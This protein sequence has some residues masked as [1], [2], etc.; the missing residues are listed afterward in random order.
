MAAKKTERLTNPNSLL[1]DIATVLISDLKH[2]PGNARVGNVDAIAESL[3][4]NKQVDRPLV[5]KS[6]GYVIAGNHTLKAARKVKWKVLDVEYLDVDDVT[7]RRLNIALNHIP[8]LGGYDRE[9]LIEMMAS[10]PDPVGTGYTD[11]E[12]NNMIRLSREVA[13]E[14]IDST[15]ATLHR[16]QVDELAE[17]AE[18]EEVQ[19]WAAKAFNAKRQ[20]EEDETPDAFL[21]AAEELPGVAQLAEEPSF[22]GEPDFGIPILRADMLITDADMPDKLDTWAGY[23]TRGNEDPDQW[24]L[25]NYGSE[26]TK[27][28]LDPS[29]MLLAFYA[30][31]EAFDTWWVNTATNI[32]KALNSGIKIA[33]SP[34]FTQ[35][36][37]VRLLNM[38]AFYRSRYV[39]RYLQEVGIKVMPDLALADD[40]YMIDL[41]KRTLP[42][43]GS[44]WASVQVQNIASTSRGAKQTDAELKEAEEAYKRSIVAQVNAAQCENL[45]VY[46]NKPG[47]ELIESLNLPCKTRFVFSRLAAISRYQANMRKL[48]DGPKG[49]P[50]L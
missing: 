43:G 34:N 17:D 39:A 40:P 10:L 1:G 3:L 48:N 26:T 44:P 16:A 21:D 33:I 50:T 42:K 9:L 18:A 32:T 20:H 49:P 31:D 47:F 14:A 5:Q 6:T 29:K 24:W 15:L 13:D 7:A 37:D 30:W 25:Y 45:L 8:E 28:M 4:K 36:Y 12:Y 41:A 27:G 35:G 22:T 2:F 38:W 23:V 19:E 46:G 11:D